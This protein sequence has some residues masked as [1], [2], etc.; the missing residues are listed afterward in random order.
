MC[1]IYNILMVL[2]DPLEFQWDKGNTDKNLVNH[3]VTNQ[4]IEEIFLDVNKR[5]FTDVLHSGNEE[6]FRVIGLTRESRL[7]FVVFTIRKE[8][9]RVISARK[10][11]KKEV[12]LY[13]KKA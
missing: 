7:L 9:V 1:G 11:N 8:K 6:R 10:I 4:E 12:N 13:E 3:G 5:I 2:P